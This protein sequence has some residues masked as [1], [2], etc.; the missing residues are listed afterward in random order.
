MPGFS[1]ASLRDENLKSSRHWIEI[2]ATGSGFKV[3]EPG[4]KRHPLHK[5]PAL[6]PALSQGERENRPPRFLDS[7]WFMVHGVV[8]GT[9]DT[10][11]DPNAAFQDASVGSD[12]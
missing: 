9:K 12:A 4:E 5:P 8:K 3:L 7:M 11:L 6:T 2:C 1:Q 10:S